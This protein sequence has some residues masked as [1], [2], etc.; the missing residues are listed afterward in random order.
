MSDFGKNLKQLRTDRN[1]SQ[2]DLAE[3][4]GIA[5]STISMYE[6][7]NREPDFE[8]LDAISNFFHVNFH[9]LLGNHSDFDNAALFSQAKDSEHIDWMK[10]YLFG[11]PDATIE[12]LNE[13]VQFARFV[14]ARDKGKT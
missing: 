2:N 11:A 7:G 10:V 14:Y 1:L 12:Q 3:M 6:N 8:R 9:D 13:V 4:L 5:K